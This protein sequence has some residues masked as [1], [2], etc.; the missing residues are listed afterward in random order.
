[1][2]L[3]IAGGRNNHLTAEGY[4]ELY[5]LLEKY[6]IEEI[7]SGG[8]KGIDSDAIEFA[9]K[10][11]LPYKIF[12]PNWSLGKSQGP[13]RNKKMAEYVSKDGIVILFPGGRGTN[14]MF[15]EAQKVDV[16]IIVDF[17]NRNDFIL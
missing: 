14:S 10:V 2:K 13:L 5:L 11:G 9:K 6:D 8:A 17:R 7:I 12:K 4:H 15:M 3:I 1:L 16:A